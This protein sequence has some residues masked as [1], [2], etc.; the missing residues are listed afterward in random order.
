MRARMA[1]Q[2]ANIDVELREVSLKAKPQA[3]LDISPKGTVPVMQLP[4]GRVLDESLDIISYASDFITPAMAWDPHH[5]L[6]L[7]NDNQFTTQLRHY[8]YFERYPEQSFESYRE[9]CL[10]F[11]TSLNQ[12][13]ENN[14]GY[15]N[16]NQLSLI[17]IAI[18]PFI[19][20]FSMVDKD[21]F[22][23]SDFKALQQWLTTLLDA[24]YFT[25]AMQKHPLWGSSQIS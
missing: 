1:L 18:M 2:L 19:R 6:I 14:G 4:D 25:K 11:I 17:D 7:E 5:P 9:A 12:Q 15:L 13:I 16:G 22:Y 3:M 23:N 21:W 24:D 20:Q 10:G 8:K